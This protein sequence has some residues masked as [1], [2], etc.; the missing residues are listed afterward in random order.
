MDFETAAIQATSDLLLRIVSI[1]DEV[2][3]RNPSAH[4]IRFLTM[5]IVFFFLK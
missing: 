5:P 1:C 3:I 2:N 4:E